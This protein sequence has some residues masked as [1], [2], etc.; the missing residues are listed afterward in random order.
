[1]G[2]LD[3]KSLK[4]ALG[5]V[6]TII[7]E[8]AP[9]DP[10]VLCPEKD[11]DFYCVLDPTLK[12]K[13]KNV[14]SFPRPLE[15]IQ[16]GLPEIPKDIPV[17]GTFGF[18]T[19]GKGFQHVVEAV[20]KEFDNA[21][22]KINIPY[23]DFVPNSKEYADFLA[24]LCIQKAKKGIEVIVTN[25]F[26]DKEQLIKWC[27]SNTL[28]CFLYDRNMPGLSATTDQAIVAE[29]PLAVSDNDTFR[30]ITSYI[31]PYPSWS[32]QDSITKSILLVKQMKEEWS[33][34]NFVKKYEIL[35]QQNDHLINRS[36]NHDGIFILPVKTPSVMDMLEKRIKKYTRKLKKINFITLAGNDTK[37]SKK[38]I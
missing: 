34:E 29:R 28:N 4:R 14:Y 6:G 5:F 9:G 7:L 2:W 10:F 26:M 30:H 17:I 18:A 22:V 37:R 32:L 35:L 13:K 19:K 16:F 3:T 11:F 38:I 24:K 20:N 31:K 33:A 21:V 23:G 36:R 27:A 1:M 25:D 8:V 12:S 15:N